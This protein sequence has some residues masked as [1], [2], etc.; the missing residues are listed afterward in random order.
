MSACTAPDDAILKWN[1]AKRKLT[2]QKYG[3]PEGT[4]CAHT[5]L[6][7]DVSADDAPSDD[8]DSLPTLDD[9]RMTAMTTR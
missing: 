2:V 4:T 1:L 3:A 8:A 6:L 7:S 9:Y 5:A